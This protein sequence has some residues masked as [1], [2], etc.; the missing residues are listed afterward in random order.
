MHPKFFWD[1][2]FDEIKWEAYKMVIA[3][4]VK[5]G[6]QEE[7]D[8]IIRFYVHEKVIRT[9]RDEIHFLPSNAIDRALKFFPQLKK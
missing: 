6:G 1:F 5:R 4:I 8:E 2:R 3:R 7:I 9:I